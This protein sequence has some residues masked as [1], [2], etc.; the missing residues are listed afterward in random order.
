MNS[1]TYVSGSMQEGVLVLSILV[2]KLRDPETA[3]S[4]RD[5]IMS[6]VDASETR[7]LVLDMKRVE[8]VG[9][10]GFLSFLSVR[11][12]LADG[13]IVLCNLSD[14]VR[15]TFQISRL[16]SADSSQIAPFIATSTVDAA[17]EKLSNGG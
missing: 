15:E 11:R 12:H 9:S 14:P 10:V 8:S 4:L 6:Q 16:I 3:Y 5:E 2:E 7:D 1:A 13:N 17:L